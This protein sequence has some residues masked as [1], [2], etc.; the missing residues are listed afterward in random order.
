M[1]LWAIFS[2]PGQSLMVID[3]QKHGTDRQT[4]GTEAIN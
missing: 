2:H 3:D 4:D 1:S